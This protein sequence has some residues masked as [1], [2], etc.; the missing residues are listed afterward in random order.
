MCEDIQAKIVE[1][2]QSI[3]QSFEFHLNTLEKIVASVT[4]KINWN[5]I[6]VFYYI[7]ISC[8]LI[9]DD[10]DTDYIIIS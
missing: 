2:E 1:E 6:I 9:S 7:N 8:L 4:E 3:K 5:F 10:F